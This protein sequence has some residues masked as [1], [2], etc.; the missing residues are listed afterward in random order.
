MNGVLEK[1]EL[2]LQE[3]YKRHPDIPRVKISS[4]NRGLRYYIE[5]PIVTRNVNALALLESTKTLME[6]NKGKPYFVKVKTTDSY[7]ADE[8]VSYLVD[9][10][11][12]S[13]QVRGTMCKGS[14]YVRGVKGHDG[15]DDFKFILE[16]SN[17]F[18]DFDAKIIVNAYE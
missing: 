17:E 11:V 15:W 7:L 5:F 4:G 16:K 14:C 3:V 10:Q 1:I 2:G 8:N 18:S 13:Q 9:Y 12:E 6:A